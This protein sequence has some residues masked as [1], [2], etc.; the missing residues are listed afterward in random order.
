MVLVKLRPY[1]VEDWPTICEIYDLAK[2]DEMASVALPKAILP[3][4]SDGSMRKLFEESAIV[5][6]EGSGRVAGFAGSR[7]SLITWLF[8]H[9]E[10]RKI[11]VATALLRELLV[12]LERPVRLNVA[13]GNIPARNLYEQFGFQVEREFMGSFQGTPCSVAKL[14]FRNRQRQCG[15]TP[16]STGPATA[17]TV[18]PVRGTWCIISYRAYGACL[19]SPV[20]SNVRLHMTILEALASGPSEYVG[21]GINHD[22]ERFVGTLQVQPLLGGIAVQLYYEAKLNTGEV[23]HAESTLL[24]PDMSGT[25]SLWPVMSELPGVLPHHAI[26]QSEAAATFSSGNREDSQNFREEITISISDDGSLTYAHAWGM[27]GGEF[28]ERSSCTLRPR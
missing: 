25:L 9:P 13:A 20:S 10:C 16:R 22:A 23:V 14:R 19:R 2:P 21:S 17:G 26:A 11:G 3:L 7:G 6:A 8:V 12:S 5:V 28:R 4:E 27:P 18:S 15:L 24:A 1:Q